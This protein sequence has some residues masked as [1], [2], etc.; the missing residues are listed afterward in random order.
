MIENKKEQLIQMSADSLQKY[1]KEESIKYAKQQMKDFAEWMRL[2]DWIFSN[3][4][5]CWINADEKSAETTEQLIEIF[6]NK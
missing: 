1:V 3:Q 6:L 4:E 2:S 5:G